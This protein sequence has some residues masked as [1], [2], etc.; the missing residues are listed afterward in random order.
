MLYILQLSS[1]TPWLHQPTVSQLWPTHFHTVG[2]DSSFT[3]GQHAIA[4]AEMLLELSYILEEQVQSVVPAGETFVHPLYTL[5][6]I[7]MASQ[8]RIGY[9]FGRKAK[10]KSS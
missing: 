10:A 8:I 4:A 1:L 3:P 9:L 5:G 2:G 6:K 7:D